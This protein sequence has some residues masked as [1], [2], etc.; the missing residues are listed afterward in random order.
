MD[1]VVCNKMFNWSIDISKYTRALYR[2]EVL[3]NK[4][5]YKSTSLSFNLTLTAL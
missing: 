3:Y 5:L 1:L 4:A 2:D